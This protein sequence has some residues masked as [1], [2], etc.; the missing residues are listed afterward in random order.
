MSR[1]EIEYDPLFKR[2]HES[3][4]ALRFLTQIELSLVTL[5]VA[6]SLS[7]LDFSQGVGRC[8]R[9]V[10]SSVATDDIGCQLHHNA[11][12]TSQGSDQVHKV[13][14]DSFVGNYFG[15]QPGVHLGKNFL[16]L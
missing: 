12:D 1:H 10:E 3:G 11:I 4:Q 9:R 8:E 13:E 5:Q 7:N 14:S 16:V 2:T 6:L 15:V